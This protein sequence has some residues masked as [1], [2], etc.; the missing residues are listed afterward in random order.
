M[1][2]RRFN[3]FQVRLTVVRESLLSVGHLR[4]QSSDSLNTCSSRGESTRV[5]RSFINQLHDNMAFSVSRKQA[6]ML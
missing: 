5:C 6:M 3:G 2:L 4:E 1:R